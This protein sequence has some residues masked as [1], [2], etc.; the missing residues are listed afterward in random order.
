MSLG[1]YSTA[2]LVWLGIGF[3]GQAL[4]S[5]RFLLQW[6]ASE[7][8]GRS[9]IPIAFWYFSIGGGLTLFCYAL[10]QGDPVFILGQGAGVFIYARNLWLIHSERRSAAHEQPA[11][12]C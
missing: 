11:D 5:A 3:A 9:T 4:F 1:D 12:R 2:Q 6:L 10:R 8:A 7:K